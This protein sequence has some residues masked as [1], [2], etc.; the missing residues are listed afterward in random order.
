M[1][2][3]AK[4]IK[5][6]RWFLHIGLTLFVIVDLAPILWLVLSSV[7]T[8]K[9]ISQSPWG[10]PETLHWENF[11][12]AWEVA[13]LGYYFGN[14]VF[15]S[16][17]ATVITILTATLASFALS[18]FRYP[19]FNRVFYV[20]FLLGLIVPVNSLLIPL[21]LLIND[22]QL[23]GTRWALII[24]YTA[25]QLPITLFIVEA[26]MRSIPS[27]LE[28]AGIMDGCGSLK[29]FWNIMLPITRPAI[30]TVFIL[31]L[32]NNW[33]EFILAL[34]FNSDDA[35]RTI[36]VGMANFSSQY[37]V[38]YATM[39]A[40]V[41]ITILPIIGVFLLLRNQIIEG[42]TAGAVKG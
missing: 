8:N 30:A 9:A 6:G 20:Y 12:H 10:W 35:V 24:V 28:E 41:L 22:L 29:L 31:N 13:R 16:V 26:F 23:Y 37:Q 17:V 11:S 33:N 34:L 36:P 7:K 21:Y 2:H 4:K 3:A 39:S 15:I 40:G 32:L 14:S 42:M 1:N 5:W 38:D 25:F 18:R 19:K 27:E